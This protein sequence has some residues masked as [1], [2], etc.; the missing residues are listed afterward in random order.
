MTIMQGLECDT[1][2]ATPLNDHLAM[3]LACCSPLFIAV[4]QM[5]KSYAGFTK[6]SVAFEHKYG[7][8]V[9]ARYQKQQISVSLMVKLD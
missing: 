3:L 7:I 5:F 9:A 4:I 6:P 8:V 1:V 2:E